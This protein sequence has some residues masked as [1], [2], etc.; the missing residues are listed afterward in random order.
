MADAP[1]A[2]SVVTVFGGSGFL[3][4]RVVDRLAAGGATVR[5]AV[6]HPERVSAGA[7]SGGTGRITS[8]FADIRN[9]ASVASAVA[10]ATAVINA[11]SAYVEKAGTT[12]TA[13]HV[14]GARHVAR[15]C[16]Q[17]GVSRLMHVSGIGADAG[18]LAPYIRAR[19]QGEQRVREAFPA[20]TIIRP[21][22]MFAAD[23]GLV[24]S[25]AAVIRQA[26]AIPLIAGGN[27][28]LQ[29]VHVCDVAAAVELCLR[30]PAARGLVYELGGPQTYTLR[31]IVGMVADKLG[32]HPL[33]VP[34]PLWLA[35]R[36][37]RVLE[38]LPNAPLTVAQV[39]LLEHD[40]VVVMASREIIAPE[41]RRRIEDTIAELATI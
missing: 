4:R 30:D 40:N 9:E 31:Q 6:R 7:K 12:Y 29:P 15:Q 32:R 8:V 37:A 36:M 3:G 41:K 24:R 34:V 5:V 2:T 19:G 10:G 17:N 20:A 33:N 27:T 38:L 11:V 21:S 25:L 1:F 14:D 26:P 16:V 28:R 35:R 22:V 23:G 39:D 13:V 18:S